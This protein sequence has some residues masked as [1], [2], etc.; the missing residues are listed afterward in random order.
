MIGRSAFLQIAAY[1]AVALTGAASIATS[2]DGSFV[3]ASGPRAS[4][5]LTE[6]QPSQTL[7]FAVRT[8]AKSYVAARLHVSGM[9]P[10]NVQAKVFPGPNAGSDAGEVTA[11]GSAETNLVLCWESTCSR[12]ISLTLEL[13]NSAPGQSAVVDYALEATAQSD[14]CDD[15]DSIF[16]EV[17]PL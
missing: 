17:S 2:C 7:Q 5:T 4:V 11:V 3:A 15:S 1:L 13:S 9:S 8:N 14:S 6:A 16:V 12:T 10:A